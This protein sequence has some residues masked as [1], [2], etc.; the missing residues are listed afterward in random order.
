MK[1]NDK[2]RIEQQ[3]EYDFSDGARG[4]FFHVPESQKMIPVDADIIRYFQQRA[5]KEQK[6]YYALINEALRREM[7][8]DK[9]TASLDELVREIV[10]EELQKSVTEK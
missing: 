10:A 8:R 5:R 9:P 7:N 4:K 6:A 3:R 2:K 1:T